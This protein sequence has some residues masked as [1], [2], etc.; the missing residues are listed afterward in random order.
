MSILG[1]NNRTENWKTA[2]EFAPFFRDGNACA[3]LARTLEEGGSPTGNEVKIELFWKGMRDYVDKVGKPKEHEL[4]DKC[5]KAYYETELFC[6]LRDDIQ[7]FNKIGTKNALRIPNAWNYDPCKVEPKPGQTGEGAL[8]NNLRNTEVDIV[9]E[10]PG[11]LFIGEAKDESVLGGSGPLV[12]VH[13]L[14]RQYVTARIL[15]RVM[16]SEKE[17][18]PFLVVADND[19]MKRTGQVQFMISQEWLKKKNVL[20]WADIRG[21]QP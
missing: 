17:I 8:F 2:Y 3:K 7:K 16:G 15:L 6:G 1:I 14:I 18:V 11:H 19:Y 5:I 12:L 9:L 20:T 4:Q 13:Q 10:T 21:L